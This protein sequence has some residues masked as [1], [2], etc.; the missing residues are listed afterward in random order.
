MKAPT[1]VPMTVL[2]AI[3]FVV[4]DVVT[5]VGAE[6]NES[7]VEATIAELV[8]KVGVSKPVEVERPWSYTSVDCVMLTLEA[9]T[10]ELIPEHVHNKRAGWE[11]MDGWEKKRKLK[12]RKV[13]LTKAP[14]R[15]SGLQT[16]VLVE[17]AIFGENDHCN[18]STSHRRLHT[19]KEL[20]MKGFL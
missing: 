8:I 18:Q 11:E 13:S 2:N 17:C 9:V 15:L 1:Q 12:E 6:D 14:V 20:V 16:R 4:L 5:M 3:G 10:A 7:L 19:Y